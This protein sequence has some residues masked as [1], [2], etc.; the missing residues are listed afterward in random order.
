VSL[1]IIDAAMLMAAVAVV[2]GVVA[3]IVV[4]VRL[5]WSAIT[6]RSRS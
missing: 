3:G 5:I 1:S 6:S 4:V 2:A